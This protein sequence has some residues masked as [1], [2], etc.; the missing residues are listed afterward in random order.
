[1]SFDYEKIKKKQETGE[2]W[3][4]YSDLF[5][6][7][8]VVFLLLY[9]V[10]SL[11]TGTHT[12]QQ[13]IQNQ[14]LAEKAQDLENQIKAYNNLKEDYL[15]KSASQREQEV[16]GQL[17]DKL[18]LLQEENK[19]EASTL[20]A[21]ALENEKKEM[22]LNKYQQLIRNII[23]SN[24]LSKS[25]IKRRDRTIASAKVTIADQVET[26]KIKDDAILERDMT[27]E[28]KE[29]VIENLDKEVALKK[30]IIAKKNSVIAK[31]QKILK[32]K[33]REIFK[34]NKDISVKKGQ[35]KTNERKI[36]KI[37]KNLANQIKALKKEQKRRKISKKNFLKKMARLK[38]KSKK[39]I[40]VLNKKNKNIKRKL[41]KVNKAVGKA[42]A[43]LVSANK[44]IK[45]QKNQKAKLDRELSS[46]QNQKAVL[47]A[48]LTKVQSEVVA[49]KAELEQTKQEFQQQVSNL[50]GQKSQL[51][52]QRNKLQN[53]KNLLSSQKKELKNINSKLAKVNTKLDKEKKQLTKVTK[54]LNQEK[55]QLTQEKTKLNTEKRKL[56]KD[57]K[58]AQ[59][60]IN[61]KKALAKQI[62]KN[63]KKAG[64]KASVD[65]GTGEV[66]LAFG[67]SYFDNGKANLKNT[68]KKTLNK[69]MPIYAESIFKDKKIAEKIKSVDIIGFSSPTYAG[70]Y[71]NPNS[72]APK[73]KKAIEYN[74]NLSIER[75]KSVF[76][77]IIDTN[78]LKYSRQRQI[79][80]LLKV[81]GR[82]YFSGALKGRA[83]AK[84]MSKKQFCAMYD[85]KKEQRVIIRFELDQR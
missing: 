21:K 58:K 28:Q 56:S 35:I 53:Q 20:R 82:S 64:I 85:C 66:V 40:L 38:S 60:I 70:R 77:H 33:Q 13:Q 25:K 9:V 83:P 65:A 26:I 63:F 8:S 2:Q 54:K 61:A 42:N 27:I 81:S 50:E 49:T 39:E 52:S 24:V 57:L 7:L 31:K 10:A 55:K 23:N 3:A 18:S 71:V 37:N 76:K 19:E 46:V 75:A 34:L 30:R 59:E 69:F 51:E 22:A 5:M 1:M 74:T 16:Y 17:M 45:T 12:L 32:S 72:L 62:S 47:D 78:K 6:V 44:T 80:P 79:T 48:E 68:M 43:L 11:R 4:S 15:E 67:N 41:Y 29:G 36:S 84:E 14:Q 73:D